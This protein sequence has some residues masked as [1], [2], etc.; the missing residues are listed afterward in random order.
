[1]YMKALTFYKENDIL[2]QRPMKNVHRQTSSASSCEIN[3][4]SV[5]LHDVAD[6]LHIRNVY[7]YIKIRMLS[8]I[9]NNNK[10]G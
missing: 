2:I 9:A 3:T 7:N 5:P 4:T 10:C 8:K 6:G 1:M